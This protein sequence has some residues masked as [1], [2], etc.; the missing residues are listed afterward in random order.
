MAVTRS[1]AEADELHSKLISIQK[2]VQ[3]LEEDNQLLNSLHDRK[4]E[5]HPSDPYKKQTADEMI[6]KLEHENKVNICLHLSV[7]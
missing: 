5:R 1:E 2:R 7:R 4:P 6:S 3:Q